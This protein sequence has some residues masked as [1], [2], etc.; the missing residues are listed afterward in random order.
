M[1]RSKTLPTT[2]FIIEGK[3]SHSLLLGRDRIHA[4]FCVPS[5]MHQC[6]IQWQGNNVEVV[7]ADASVSV[8]TADPVVW[9]IED[10]E[11]FS[12]KVWEANFQ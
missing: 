1:I 3:G 12:R 4:N 6:L 10:F 5:T 11:C 7:H 9:E 2:F 8:A